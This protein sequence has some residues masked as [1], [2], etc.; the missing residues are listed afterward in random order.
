MAEVTDSTAAKPKNTKW[1]VFIV[2]A[3]LLGGVLG[4]AYGSNS[5]ESELK[6]K[7][8][9]QIKQLEEDVDKAKESAS[10]TV[11]E[12]QAAVAEG[13]QTLESL[14]TENAQLKSTIDAQ[15]KKIADLEKQLAEA[16]KTTPA[17][18]PTPTPPTQ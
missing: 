6:T 3:L 12:G 7:Y 11:E 8:A 15:T 17:P 16:K 18:T 10:G 4:Y 2:L 5:T 9:A 13:Q 14:Q 1:I